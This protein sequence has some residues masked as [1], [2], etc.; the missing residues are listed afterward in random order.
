[1][2]AWRPL[3][4]GAVLCLVLASPGWAQDL[5]PRAYVHVPIDGT[6]LILGFGVSEG[7]IVTDPT[8]PITDIQ[9]SVMTPSVGAGRS[10]GLLGRTAQVFAVLPFSWADVSGSVLGDSRAARRS[11]LSDVRLRVSW[12]VKGAPASTVAELRKTP[13]RTILGVSLNV[14]APIGEYDPEKLINLGT[15]RWAFRPEV[16]VSQ[17]IGQRW[18]LDTYAGLWLF[19]ANDEYYPGTQAKTQAPMGSFQAHVSYNFQPQLWAALDLTYYAGGRTTVE[20]VRGEDLQSN[21]RGGFTVALPVGQRHSIKI[22][23]SRGAIV[24]RGADFITYSFAW[25][26]AWAPRPTPAPRSTSQ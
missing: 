26:T 19:S 12:L 22:A 5:D 4:A 11:G 8:L 17:P 3:R 14:A 18:L 24:R 25:Q 1:M 21:V 13:R 15:N 2:T 9:A 16:A 6:F 10:F 20:G 7:G 23:V